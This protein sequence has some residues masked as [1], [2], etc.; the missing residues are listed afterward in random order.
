[1]VF[2]LILVHSHGRHKH[3]RQNYPVEK[4]FLAELK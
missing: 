4:D 3:E 2:S 1:M